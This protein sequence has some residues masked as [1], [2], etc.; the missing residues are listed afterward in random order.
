MWS[1]NCRIA[2][3]CLSVSLETKSIFGSY[4]YPHLPKLDLTAQGYQMN[5]HWRLDCRIFGVLQYVTDDIYYFPQSSIP[6]LLLHPLLN[7]LATPVN[8]FIIVQQ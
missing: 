6:C 1:V 5:C 8:W 7:S 2:N 4:F 3:G